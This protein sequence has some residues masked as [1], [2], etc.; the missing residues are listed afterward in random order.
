MCIE[1]LLQAWLWILGTGAHKIEA[2]ISLI[3]LSENRVLQ[4]VGTFMKCVLYCILHKHK[5]SIMYMIVAA[6]QH[7]KLD[8]VVFFLGLF[9]EWKPNKFHQ[10]IGRQSLKIS[11]DQIEMREI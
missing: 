5:Y 4:F 6:K 7:Q 1:S 8:F 10:K 9:V 3:S 11:I 2:N